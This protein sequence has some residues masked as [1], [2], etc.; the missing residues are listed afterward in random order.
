MPFSE[1][2]CLPPVAPSRRGLRPCSGATSPASGR[3]PGRRR[4][5][6]PRWGRPGG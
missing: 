3:R 4:G 1:P 5:G 6:G 2:S